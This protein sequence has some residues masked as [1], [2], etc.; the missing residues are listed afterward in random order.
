MREVQSDVE[1]GAVD[2]LAA[3]GQPLLL[4]RRGLQPMTLTLLICPRRCGDVS[5][6]VATVKFFGG[7]W[8]K[9]R[10]CRTLVCPECGTRLLPTRREIMETRAA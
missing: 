9:A 3:H 8:N 7:K 6:R 1:A 5:P 10:Y 4:A 2:L